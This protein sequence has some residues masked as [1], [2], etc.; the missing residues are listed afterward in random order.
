MLSSHVEWPNDPDP[1]GSDESPFAPRPPLRKLRVVIDG[2]LYRVPPE[3][4]HVG[5]EEVLTGLLLHDHVICFR[6]ADNGPPP[7][8]TMYELTDGGRA[9]EGWVTVDPPDGRADSRGI[10]FCTN[11][12]PVRGTAYMDKLRHARDEAVAYT[13]LSPTVAAD[14]R[15]ADALALQVALGLDADIFVTERPYLY[16]SRGR[17]SRTKVL[18]AMEALAIV[19][20]YLRSQGVHSVIR[21][22]DAHFPMR[23]G[24]YFAVGAMELMPSVWRWSAACHQESSA[25]GDPRLGELAGAL[26]QRIARALES[27][28]ELHQIAN[29]AKSNDTR[30]SVLSGLDDALLLLLAAADVSARVAHRVLDLG[31]RHQ[32]LAGWGRPDWVKK[33]REKD[34]NLAALVGERTP[35]WILVRG[36]A[37]LRDSIHAEALRNLLSADGATQSSVLFALPPSRAPELSAMFDC[38]GGAAA[39][40]VRE[41]HQGERYADPGM[42]VDQLFTRTL[43]FLHVVMARTPVERLPHVRAPLP[44]S[45]ESAGRVLN[46]YSETSRKSIRWQL[47][48]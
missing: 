44:D 15:A 39:W 1:H 23:R 10:V 11:R 19:G 26:V 18:R 47:G 2:D 34:K 36:L 17:S 27:R 9:Y 3:L 43:G 22:Q 28:D 30:Y 33:V 4:L 8:T 46:R 25:T 48:L 12:R 6:Y 32:H 21:N 45:P 20:L 14:K 40:G 41:T 42:F 24:G 38:F 5:P 31:E 37:A 35:G 7:G 13:D 16:L 29:R